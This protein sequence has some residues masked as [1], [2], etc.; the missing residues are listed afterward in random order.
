[1]ATARAR[2]L[3]RVSVGLVVRNPGPERRHH[4]DHHRQLGFPTPTTAPDWAL[5]DTEVTAPSHRHRYTVQVRAHAPSTLMLRTC[6][7]ALGCL[8]PLESLPR[9][10]TS[11]SPPRSFSRLT[12]PTLQ[13]QVL[14]RTAEMKGLQRNAAETRESPNALLLI[15]AATMRPGNWS[16]HLTHVP[17]NA[18]QRITARGTSR[19]PLAS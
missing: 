6:T 7:T 18:P 2:K 9:S 12:P 8:H 1:M 14:G 16:Q 17:K 13:V 10:I 15:H 5:E 11:T 19:G 4:R 3:S